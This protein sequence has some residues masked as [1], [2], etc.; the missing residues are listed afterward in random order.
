MRLATVALLTLLASGCKKDSTSP[1]D[2]LSFPPLTSQLV[3]SW[4]VRGDRTVGQ[5][6]TGTLTSAD[7]DGDVAWPFSGENYWFEMWRVRVVS[8][9]TVTVTLNAVPDCHIILFQV[10]NLSDVRPHELGDEADT[11]TGQTQVSFQFAAQPGVDY[12][13]H[14][15]GPHGHQSV[16]YTVGFN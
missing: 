7:C 15:S 12:L 9:R 8:S 2:T 5:S 10:V 4:C 11:A 1:S 3:S 6:E 14:V 16:S 13:I